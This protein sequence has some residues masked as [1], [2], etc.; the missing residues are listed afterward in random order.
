[1]NNSNMQ[2]Y[3]RDE[4]TGVMLRAHVEVFAYSDGD[5]VED[6]I[7]AVVRNA[8]DLSVTSAELEAHCTDWPS[9]YHLSR[10]RA[11]LLRPYANLLAG[12]VLEIGAGCG[13]ITR[14]LGELGGRVTAIE[15]SFR[16]ASIAASR[17]RD[18]PNVTVICDKFQGFEDE[19]RFDVV[20]LIGVLEYAQMFGGSPE[21]VDELLVRA[22]QYL[23]PDG[24]LLLAIE[25]KL[26]LKYFAGM[27]ED[28]VN[29]GM[30]GVE[31]LYRNNEPITF[32]RLELERQ[33]AIAG[34]T[35]TAFSYPFP[36]YKLPQSV[37]MSAAMSEKQDEFNAAAFA[38]ES[39]WLDPQLTLP[40]LFSL[41]LAWNSVGRNGLVGEL[42]NSFLV[43]AS[44]STQVVL[45]E[46]GVLAWHFST[47][48]KLQYCKSARFKRV[49]SQIRVERAPLQQSGSVADSDSRVE[50]SPDD[51]DYLTGEPYRTGFARILARPLWGIEEVAEYF[52][53]YVKY[54]V[55]RYEVDASEG[56]P[57]GFDHKLRGDSLDVLPQNLLVVGEGFKSIDHEWRSREPVAVGFVT[58]RALLYLLNA[59]TRCGIPNDFALARRGEF[60]NQLFTALYGASSVAQLESF[61]SMEWTLQD[62]VAGLSVVPP[63]SSW[64]DAPLPVLDSSTVS[65]GL[66]LVEVQ[67]LRAQVAGARKSMETLAVLAESYVELA[68]APR[69][70]SG[71]DDNGSSDAQA[72]F[73]DVLSERTDQYIATVATRMDSLSRALNDG[74]QREQ[75]M[76]AELV[77]TK[78]ALAE[79]LAVGK[80]IQSTLASLMNSRSWRLTRPLRVISRMLGRV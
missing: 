45:E 11:N 14:Y 28:H 52:R 26:G 5:E 77:S 61:W 67:Q 16:R 7:A 38:A 1:M 63:Y 15:G 62:S 31:S 71:E 64:A 12:D 80:A 65:I 24:I 33:L 58:F 39:A 25:N 34:F 60:A 66:L 30:Y 19:R 55:E 68:I 74:L 18:L 20:T 3:R 40:S 72:G 43:V 54:L 75:A 51:E 2:T 35:Q 44:P 49:G 59:I 46:P 13:A 76:D 50:Y 57:I 29:H 8:S 73:S 23:K 79:S 4:D 9:R 17:T 70:A 37:V 56:E 47:S 27:P 53:V 32:G 41:E 10:T 42:A 21:A 78:G 69:D 36:D 48:R 6:R 22:R